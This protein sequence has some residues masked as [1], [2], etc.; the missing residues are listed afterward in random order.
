MRY[1]IVLLLLVTIAVAAPVPKQLKAK[2][3]DAE[4]FVGEWETVASEQD[5]RPMAKA[6][7]TFDADLTMWSRSPTEPGKGNK[8]VIKIDPEKG[9]KE[10]TIGTYSGIYEF[11]GD[12]IRVLFAYG[13][14]RPTG[15]DGQ[16]KAHYV[17]L[18]RVK[19]DG[20]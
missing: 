18:R 3:P 4:V 2:R 5:G 1:A 19:G 9:P 12:D 20:K 6:V 16:Q 15:F 14:T 7:W 11:D 17:L 10:I 13:T 8:W